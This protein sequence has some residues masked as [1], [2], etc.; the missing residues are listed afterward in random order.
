MVCEHANKHIK[1]PA[2]VAVATD[3]TMRSGR[4]PAIT[5]LCRFMY[6]CCQPLPQS[7][8]SC[9]HSCRYGAGTPLSP[10]EPLP[11]AAANT[12]AMDCGTI[13][14]D[15]CCA[16]A[17]TACAGAAK[18][19]AAARPTSR[20]RKCCLAAVANEL[21]RQKLPK[22]GSSGHVVNGAAMRISAAARQTTLQ[23]SPDVL[24]LG[25]LLFRMLTVGCGAAASTFA[26]GTTSGGCAAAAAAHSKTAE[27]F[28]V[29]LSC[30][31]RC[32]GILPAHN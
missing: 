6:S 21:R 5:S 15:A 26:G 11:A 20:R 18:L 12:A 27:M 29:K 8:S 2:P 32:F 17:A 22:G 13:P 30:K 14:A 4:R 24:P 23:T 7:E 28:H 31:P 25:L 3:T 16:N 19:P 9:R 10:P 1:I